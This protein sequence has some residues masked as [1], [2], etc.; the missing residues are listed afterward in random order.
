MMNPW[1]RFYSDFANNPK[2][3]ALSEPMQRRYVMLL[4]MKN[5]GDLDFVIEKSNVTRNEVT[6][7]NGKLAL[8]A[9]TVALRITEEEALLTKECLMDFDLIDEHWNL[10]GWEKKQYI[11]D[12]KDSTNA[13]RQRRYREKKRNAVT[14]LRNGDVT[15]EK[16]P[17]TDTDNNNNTTSANAPESAKPEWVT[18]G[19]KANEI[20][21]GYGFMP[22]NTSS[23]IPSWLSWGANPE[24][25]IYPTI[26]RLCESAKKQ[27]KTIHNLKYFNDAVAEA[28]KTRTQTMPEVTKHDANRQVPRKNQSAH[29]NFIEGAALWLAEQRED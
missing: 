20:V 17:D 14:A 5:N 8:R 21:Q 4:C 19:A 16:R 22:M 3:Q 10:N 26:I 27:G 29:E 28:M 1:F 2:V 9:V 25:D 18:V 11:S 12:L 15:E 13:E 23:L 24:T 6:E 7:R